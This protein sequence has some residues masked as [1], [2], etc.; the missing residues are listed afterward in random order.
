MSRF[1]SLR[2]NAGLPPR[3]DEDS[4]AS[5]GPFLDPYRLHIAGA[6]VALLITGVAVLSIPA[7]L[8][9]VVDKGI[10]AA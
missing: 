10:V 4:A 6:L 9:Y 2:Q 5:W 8:R 1:D 3:R 7:G